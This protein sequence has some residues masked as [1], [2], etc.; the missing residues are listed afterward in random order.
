MRPMAGLCGDGSKV[1]GTSFS[2][3]VSVMWKLSQIL[4]RSRYENGTIVVLLIVSISGLSEN[5]YVKS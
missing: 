3:W 5:I 4:T 1:K 2:W